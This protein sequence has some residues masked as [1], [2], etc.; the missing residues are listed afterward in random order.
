MKSNNEALNIIMKGTIV[1][2]IF[3]TLTSLPF[4][5]TGESEVKTRHEPVAATTTTTT[6]LE[7]FDQL[8]TIETTAAAFDHSG[9]QYPDR[10]SNP[11]GGCDNTDPAIP[12]CLE[13][14]STQ[15][16]EVAC[17]KKY[18]QAHTTDH[19]ALL[20]QCAQ[21]FYDSFDTIAAYSQAAN[22]FDNAF[23]LQSQ[24]MYNNAVGSLDVANQYKQSSIA[25]LQPCLP[26]VVQRGGN[27]NEG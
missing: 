18:Q 15:Q 5:L 9:C 27:S 10:W 16:G 25:A 14:M 12:E 2:I 8:A 11:E 17:V 4:L 22:A 6:S 24:D 3:A 21:A 13:E 7:K 23:V 1:A 19:E 26:Y 20:K